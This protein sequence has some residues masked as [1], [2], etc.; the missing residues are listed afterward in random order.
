MPSPRGVTSSTV[1]AT[2]GATG[3]GGGIGTAAYGDSE[4]GS[5][6]SAW[7]CAVRSGPMPFAVDA[8]DAAFVAVSTSAAK[9]GASATIVGA[10]GPAIGLVGASG[11]VVEAS[12]GTVFVV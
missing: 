7:A 1:G 3:I 10:V 6:V 9:S 12:G 5:P 2:R 4:V 8:A 11:C